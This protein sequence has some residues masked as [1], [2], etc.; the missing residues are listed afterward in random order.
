LRKLFFGCL[1][2]LFLVSLAYPQN[3][4][5][6]EKPTKQ[7][8]EQFLD[9]M[10]MKQMMNQLVDGMKAA[11]KKGAEETFK[12]LVPNA[13][14]EQLDRVYS[15]TDE[16]F[17]DFPIDEMLD[18]II[19]IYQRHFT[20]AD[21]DAI[22]AFY[23]SPTGVKLLKERPAMMTESMQAGQDVMLKRLPQILDRIKAQIAKL[24]DEDSKPDK[25]VKQ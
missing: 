15:I 14:Q 20:K 23:K 8:I 6:T 19:P 10:Q 9:L 3:P 7:Q 22:I 12:Q 11:Q 21:L 5:D 2:T 4:S 1:I 25:Q 17:R 13:R 24:A 16:A 18:V